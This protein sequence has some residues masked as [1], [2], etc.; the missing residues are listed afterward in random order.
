MLGFEIK[1]MNEEVKF[2]ESFCTERGAIR[3]LKVL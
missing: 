2:A 3:W 1:E